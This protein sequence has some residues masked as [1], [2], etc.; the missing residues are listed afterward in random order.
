LTYINSGAENMDFV[1]VAS[2]GFALLMLIVGL[3]LGVGGTYWAFTRKGS[4]VE[5]LR[6]KLREIDDA[7]RA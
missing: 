2:G 6:A 4:E 3:A 1:P 5:T 7:R